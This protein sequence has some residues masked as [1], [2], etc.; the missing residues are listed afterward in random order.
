MGQLQLLQPFMALGLAAL[1]LNEHVSAL[2]LGVTLA[3][4]GCVAGAKRYA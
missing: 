2:M 4:V 3:A 1:L